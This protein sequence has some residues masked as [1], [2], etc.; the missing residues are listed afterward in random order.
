M[1]VL[2]TGISGFAGSFL[3]EHL[4]TQGYEVWGVVRGDAGHVEHLQEQIHLRTANITDRS[5]I[6]M[7]LDECRPERIY[8]LAAQA[9]VPASWDDPWTTLE[10][11]IRG[12][13]NI[14]I[15]VLALELPAR[16]LVVGSNEEYGAIRQDALPLTETIEFR[17]SSPYAVSKIAQDM[18]GFQ[19]WES[20]KLHTVRVRA[21]NHIGPRQS[22]Q[23]VAAS[24][25]K[26]IAEIEAGLQPPI[27]K[28]GNLDA[29]R[30]FTDVRDIASAYH[31]VLEQGEP[32][33]VYN[34]GSGEA[35]SIKELLDILLAYSSTD[36]TVEQDPA[37]MRPADVPLA[38]ADIT[39][40]TSD[41][42]WQ[43]S[44]SFEESLETV[45]AYWR[46]IVRRPA[47]KMED[48]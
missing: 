32:G 29:R 12:Q 34:V 5:R 19:Y 43:P 6:T 40:I 44:I 39:K 37:R 28:V 30:D 25:A 8:H 45:L 16:M 11:N 41:V 33:D 1:R 47:Y 42:G 14:I 48:S 18:L 9:F 31:L 27:L 15:A 22:P 3:A 20:H 23:F 7:V 21:F 24:F 13:L 36:V 38:Y 35:H 46:E 10:I 17:P 4:L 26:Q 2:I